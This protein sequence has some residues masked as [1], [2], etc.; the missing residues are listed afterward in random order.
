MSGAT[1]APRS[2]IDIRKSETAVSKPKGQRRVLFRSTL[3]KIKLFQ[4]W[5]AIVKK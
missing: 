3:K 2:E 5:L 4:K 1:F